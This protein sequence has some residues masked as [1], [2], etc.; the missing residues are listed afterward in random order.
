MTD[1]EFA[2]GRMQCAVELAKAFIEKNGDIVNHHYF[3]DVA[4]MCAKMVIAMEN[5]FIPKAKEND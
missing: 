5:T 4:K 3:V 1:K 2:V